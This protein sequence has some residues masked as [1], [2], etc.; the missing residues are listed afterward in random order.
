MAT[1]P[2]E[3]WG[4]ATGKPTQGASHTPGQPLEHRV[5]PASKKIFVNL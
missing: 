2:A 5:T 1:N 3:S 4:F